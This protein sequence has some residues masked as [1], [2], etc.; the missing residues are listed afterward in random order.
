MCLIVMTIVITV[1]YPLWQ[2]DSK[3]FSLVYGLNYAL[4]R[5]FW[6]IALCY[7]I[8]AC[9][10]NYGGLINRFLSCPLWQP[11]SNL[12]FAIYLLHFPVIIITM[13][14]IKSVPYFNE[15]NVVSVIIY[16]HLKRF[17]C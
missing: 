2:L 3:F 13:A 4:S 5:C 8:Y 1:N 10:N 6:S 12:L 11:L 14:S 16:P 15:I 17:C 9:T 7:I